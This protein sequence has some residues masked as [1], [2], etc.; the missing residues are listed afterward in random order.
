[1]KRPVFFSI[2]PIKYVHISK[3]FLHSNSWTPLL[4]FH[5]QTISELSVTVHLFKFNS[6][7]TLWIH[8]RWSEQNYSAGFQTFL[9][10]MSIFRKPLLSIRVKRSAPHFNR[11]CHSK[12][13]HVF[14]ASVSYASDSI[15]H[16]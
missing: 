1:M 7:H 2:F 4:N 5:A 6:C 10:N 3:F 12:T 14:T 13:C 8:K 16:F 9:S 15:S 11:F